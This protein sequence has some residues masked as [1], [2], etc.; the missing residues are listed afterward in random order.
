MKKTTCILLFTFI[1][2]AI[3]H[4]SAYSQE[5]KAIEKTVKAKQ[6]E[7]SRGANPNIKSD[8]P[9]EDKKDSKSRGAYT[10]YIYFENYTDLYV[11]VYVNGYYMGMIG[12][13]GDMTVRTSD[14]ADIYCVS[15]GGTRYWSDAGSCAGDY[16][17]KL[18]DY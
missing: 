10:C 5:K 12:P 13:Y 3:S 2:A 9:T 6:L 18:Y 16:H 15:A 17:Y 7:S 8:I 14:Y 4:G 11:K 1:L